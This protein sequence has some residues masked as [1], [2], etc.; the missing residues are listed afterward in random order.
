MAKTSNPKTYFCEYLGHEISA[1]AARNCN[2][3]NLETNKCNQ[4]GKPCVAKQGLEL[5]A[6]KLSEDNTIVVDFRAAGKA[7]E[8]AKRQERY[9]RIAHLADHLTTKDLSPSQ[10]IKY[11][12]GTVQ[13]N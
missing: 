8:E 6:Q 3:L 13:G 1:V 5:F 10:K 11:F 2:Y 7:Q 4:D 12:P 9:G